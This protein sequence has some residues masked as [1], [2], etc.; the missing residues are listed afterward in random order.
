MKKHLLATIIFIVLLVLTYL[1]VFKDCDFSLLWTSLK[2]TNPIYLFWAVV[3]MF[4]YLFGGSFFLKRILKYFNYSVSFGKTFGYYLTEFYFSA[5]TPSYVG[6]QPVEMYEMKKD[7]IGYETSGL[8]VLFNSLFNRLALIFLALI[9]FGFFSQTLFGL[10]T[11]YNIVVLMGFL[12]TLL[13][14]LV[15]IA[16]IYSSR[17]ANWVLKITTFLI[18]HLKFIKDKDKAGEKVK[19]MIAEYQKCSQITKDNPRLMLE[20]FS[21]MVLQRLS[22]LLAAYFVYRSFG[23]KTYSLFYVMAFQIC[24]TLGSDLMPTPGGVMINES[25]LLMV[26]K[27][28]YGNELALSGMLLLRTINFYALVV[29]SGI[30]YLL[31]H[32]RFK[33]KAIAKQK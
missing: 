3:A 24:I 2:N 5:I 31:F 17:V 11:F 16:L 20:T 9:F 33:I 27:L 13:V 21:L 7:G 26:N 10:N 29:I 28:L 19:Q 25:L 6:G 12:T 14:I 1:F 4:F 8:I 32:Y 23:L 22:I 30:V 15:F 18:K